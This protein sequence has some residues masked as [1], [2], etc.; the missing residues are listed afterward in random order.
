MCKLGHLF[1]LVV[2]TAAKGN[3]TNEQSS[4]ERGRGKERAD[5][6]LIWIYFFPNSVA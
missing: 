5:L 6:N 3:H 4:E 1:L 2:L